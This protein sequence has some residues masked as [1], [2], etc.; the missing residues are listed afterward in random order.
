MRRLVEALGRGEHER[1]AVVVKLLEHEQLELLGIVHGELGHDVER[2]LRLGVDNTG[3]LLEPFDEG[4]AAGLILLA[5]GVKVFGADGVERGGGDL[6]DRRGAQAALAPLHGIVVEIAVARDHA[7]DARTAGAEALGHGVDDD[8]V[9]LIALELQQAHELLTAVDELAVHL[10]ADEEQVVLLG[11]VGHEPELFLGEDGAGR[12]AGVGEEDGAGVLVDAGFNA[13]TDG[14]PVVFFRR[15]GDGADGCAGERDE[16]AVVR[17]ERLGDDDLIALIEDAAERDL[18]RLAAAGGDEHLL[19]GDGRVDLA[20]VVD[21][22]VDHL[23]HAV[24]RGVGQHRLAEVLDGVKIGRGRGDIGLTDVQVVEL[25]SLFR[26]L[27]CVGRE[28]AHGREAA[29]FDFAGKFHVAPPFLWIFLVPF[30]S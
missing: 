25:L 6:V 5:H 3:D 28:F 10:V 27:V 26:R 29:L 1:V 4:V 15:R 2:A 11:D 12:V 21:D 7:A 8:D 19:V 13:L 20:V 16:R 17:V 30:C 22:G 9:V 23:R 14:K 24:G 18:Q